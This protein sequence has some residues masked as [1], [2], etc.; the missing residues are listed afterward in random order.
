LLRFLRSKKLIELERPTDPAAV[1]SELQ[2]FAEYQVHVCGLTQATREVSRRRV[3]AFLLK[4]FGNGSVCMD[5]LTDKDLKRFLT[6]YTAN[7]TAR[8]RAVIYFLWSIR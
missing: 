2:A 8:S 5:R 7:C 1:A 4:C 3:R 6:R